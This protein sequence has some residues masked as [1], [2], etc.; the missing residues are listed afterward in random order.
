[1]HIAVIDQVLRGI[2]K[3]PAII[4]KGDE[5]RQLAVADAGRELNVGLGTIGIDADRPP[6]RIVAGEFIAEIKIGGA[7]R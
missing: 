4:A 3:E 7:F 2:D 5:G 6:G 1:M